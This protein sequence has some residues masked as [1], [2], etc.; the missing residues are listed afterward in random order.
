MN[1][2]D[3]MQASQNSSK[4]QYCSFTGKISNILN[5]HEAWYY[6]CKGCNKKVDKTIYDKCQNCQ[7]NNEDSIPR[8]LVKIIVED[9]TDSAR[10][11]TF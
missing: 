3:I 5:R 10:V 2:I 11:T 9:E 7:K 4:A 6:S 8:Y 1:I